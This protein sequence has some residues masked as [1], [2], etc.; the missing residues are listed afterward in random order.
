MRWIVRIPVSIV[1]IATLG[2]SPS[3]STRPSQVAAA[4]TQQRANWLAATRGHVA[5]AGLRSSA[6]IDGFRVHPDPDDNGVIH[7][8]EGENVVVN[9]TD[10][11]SRPPAPQ[12]Y[13]VVN[14]GDGPNQRVGCGPCRQDHGYVAGRYT[15]VA[16]LDGTAADWSISLV[17]EVTRQREPKHPS[18]FTRFGFEPS[19]IGVGDFGVVYLPIPPPP[20]ITITDIPFPTCTPLDAV[21]FGGPVFLPDAIGVEFF[22]NEPGTCTV[23][24]FGT[25]A[26]G[27]PFAESS[28]VTVQ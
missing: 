7:V 1:I 9:A 4:D 17:V 26:T 5:S 19:T 13:L 16:S 12:S 2:C 15:L 14:W 23:T 10:I 3:G 25:D 24:V 8:F 21:F 28:T 27:E 20:G 18:L 6:V 22:A 11:A